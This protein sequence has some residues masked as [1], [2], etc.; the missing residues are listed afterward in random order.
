[1]KRAKGE[2][3]AEAERLGFSFLGAVKP[4]QT[5]HYQNYR[6]WV[7][8]G[9]YADMEYLARDYVISDR[10]DPQSL[11]PGVG[12][13]L[14]GGI[15]YFPQIDSRTIHNKKKRSFGFIAAY[16]SILDY[17]TTLK[18]M[19]RSLSNRINQ[20][21]SRT[22]KSRI[23]VDSGPVMEKDFAYMAGLGW[24]GRNSLL[25]TPQFG[26]FCLIG[27]LFLDL[28]LPPDKPL[29][30]DICQ[31]CRVCIDACPT[32]CIN[33]DR[34]INAANCISYQT[35]ENKR[36]FPEPLKRNI[37]GW[38]FGCDICQMVCPENKKL[39]QSNQQILDSRQK[40]LISQ[41]VDLI[42]AAGLDEEI[43]NARFLETP[44]SRINI[45]I[46][47]RNVANALEN[48]SDEA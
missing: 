2:I 17:H 3:K 32:G 4:E 15:H 41:E 34:T 48:S 5:P 20:I 37:D 31:D 24:I 14:V 40:P 47:H 8:K 19:F 46:F 36:A 25:I 13:V 11:L 18:S 30:E 33:E 9:L 39:F 44:V 27:C 6:K 21:V 35:I 16:G 26:S 7:R 1:M 23:F 43:F 29:E 22:V 38:I 42:S 45:E 10:E 28:D 12:S